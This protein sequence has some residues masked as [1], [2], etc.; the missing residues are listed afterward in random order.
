[1]TYIS[2]RLEALQPAVFN[3]FKA[4][5]SESKC[6]LVVAEALYGDLAQRDIRDARCVAVAAFEAEID[7]SANGH[8]IQ[9]PI[10]KEGGSLDPGQNIDGRERL[11]VCHQ[12]QISDF[13]DRAAA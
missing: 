9:V 6:R 7:R 5:L 4:D 2:A 10:R 8:G 11:R 13:L 1:E 12:R 3:E